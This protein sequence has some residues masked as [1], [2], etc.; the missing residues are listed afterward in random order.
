ME[1]CDTSS[2]LTFIYHKTMELI[3]LFK[4]H[5]VSNAPS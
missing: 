5:K 3:C 4:F 2:F 1:Y